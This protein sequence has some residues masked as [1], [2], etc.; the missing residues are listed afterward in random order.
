MALTI[1]QIIEDA[2]HVEVDPEDGYHAA[3]PHLVSHLASL[4]EFGAREFVV[5]AHIA[6][7][8][9]G[10]ECL[11]YGGPKGI[12]EA[13]E[14]LSRAAQGL[15]LSDRELAHMKNTVCTASALKKPWYPGKGGS[16]VAVSK[17]LH[18]LR[19][20]LYVIWDSRVER[21]LKARHW[22]GQAVVDGPTFLAYTEMCRRLAAEPAFETVHKDLNRRLGYES[23]G[24]RMS[25]L[26]A[27]ELVMFAAPLGGSQQ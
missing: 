5:A 22:G 19:P 18:F 9:I 15:Q 12:Q 21:Y 26:R 17:M 6:F 10:S 27:L 24:F 8:W 25:A 23:M 1:A 14:A 2:R 4:R 3:Y 16:W 20:D 13:G 7:G 11:L